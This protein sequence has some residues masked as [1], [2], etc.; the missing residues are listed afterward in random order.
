MVVSTV[1]NS[2]IA[3]LLAA[4]AIHNKNVFSLFISLF[5]YVSL[6]YT[7]AALPI[8]SFSVVYE[9][10]RQLHLSTQVGVKVVGIV[11][12][13]FTS[14]LL[15]WRHWRCFVT[16]VRSG[17]HKW[18][19]AALLC[20]IVSVITS[21]V[22]QASIGLYPSAV[23]LQNMSSALLMVIFILC[24]G[25]VLQVERISAAINQEKICWLFLVVLLVMVTIAAWEILTVRA[26]AGYPLDSKHWMRRASSLLFNPNVLGFWC[27]LAAT[28]AAYHFHSQRTRKSLSVVMLVLAS[29]GILLSG[30]RSGLIF[31]L[32][33]LGLGAVL[34]RPGRGVRRRSIFVPLFIFSAGM[35]T[36]SSFIKGLAYLA[37]RAYEGLFTMTL[38]VDRFSA[39][40]V[41][42]GYYVLNR[43]FGVVPSS[44]LSET[45]ETSIDGR[46]S[47]SLVDNG[48]LAMLGDVGAVG[49][50]TWLTVWLVLAWMGVQALSRAPGVNSAYSLS[51]VLGCALTGL[52]MRAFQ[53]FPIWVLI[54]LVLAMCLA[55][56]IVVLRTSHPLSR[57]QTEHSQVFLR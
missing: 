21:W 48:Y 56:F 9:D 22:I 16:E 39:M 30:S 36:I 18:L 54:S 35:I 50:V 24:F 7:Y 3:L 10:V 26:W 8:F 37:G 47:G 51:L 23:T 46:F 20:W 15:V 4:Y 41:E 31:C 53:V 44:W 55:W 17:T 32:F 25:V 52:F 12:L 14:G 34:L 57:T 27:G 49:L 33:V 5:L 11:F 13:L 29:F 1:L 6:H 42:M 19:V 38:L 40:P 2:V 45:T 43:M 28:F